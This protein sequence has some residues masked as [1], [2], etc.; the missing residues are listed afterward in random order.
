MMRSS[1]PVPA[2]VSA[3]WNRLPALAMLL[4]VASAAS[5]LWF[6]PL[7]FSTDP[8]E[9]WNAYQA[10]RA[11]GAGALYPPP[12]SL[13]GNNYPP[14]SFFVVG[15]LGRMIGDPI[16]A[17][18]LI[19]L[20]SLLGVAGLIFAILR[21]LGRR[22]P[23]PAI[24]ALLFL[25]LNA[26]I[27]RDY[28]ALDDPQWLG[29]LLVTA[30]VLAILPRDAA[31][32]PVPGRVILAA[33][34]MLLGGLTKQNLVGWPIALTLWLGW[35][36]R[37]ALT[38]WIA[39]GLI[40]GA[41]ALLLCQFTFG[42]DFIA[43]LLGTARI[44]SFERIIHRAGGA[45][46]VTA[47][48]LW[49]SWPVV[50]RAPAD[51]RIDLV[52]LA[53]LVTVPLGIIERGGAGVHFNA[54][55]EAAIALCL[56][57]ALAFDD[58]IGVRRDRFIAVIALTALFVAGFAREI[59][60]V[61]KFPGGQ[62]ASRAMEQR[63]AAVR[64]EVACEDQALCFR[65]GQPFGIDFFLYSQ[66]ARKTGDTRAL[67]RAL[68][69]HRFAAVQ[70]DPDLPPGNPDRAT[71]PILRRLARTMRPVFVDATGR[72]LLMPRR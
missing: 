10:V 23:V 63:I 11:M 70:I 34:L 64:G 26:T 20:A 18:R 44:Y 7:R 38:W 22:T 17:G 45:V 67:D 65:T 19:A 47:I 25:A 21:R 43:A 56:G 61:R 12:G 9:G 8:N 5:R 4:I 29:H 52:R 69:D 31:E 49:W 2:A 50:R 71:D 6:L 32:A 60:E 16:L 68:A 48:L 40:G 24:G 72:T 27:L 36:C 59:G 35:H 39:A 53:V 41:V 55:F 42:S 57:A 62:A 30:G 15:A 3:S 28:V 58:R 1:P 13:I 37:T 14:L 33:L 54:H 46:V 66:R 51:R